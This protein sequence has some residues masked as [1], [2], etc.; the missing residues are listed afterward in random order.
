[1]LPFKG[2][3]RSLN[4]ELQWPRVNV[5]IDDKDISDTEIPNELKDLQCE[6]AIAILMLPIQREKWNQSL[7]TMVLC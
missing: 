2:K 1:M 3:K 7:M 4:Q 6:V 5:K